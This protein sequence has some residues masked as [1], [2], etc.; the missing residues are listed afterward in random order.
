MTTDASTADE[1]S[2]TRRGFLSTLGSTAACVAAAAGRA[3]AA[4][5]STDDSPDYRVPARRKRRA[6]DHEVDVITSDEIPPGAVRETVHRR[7]RYVNV[8]P[9]SSLSRQ[10]Y[11]DFLSVLRDVLYDRTLSLVDGGFTVTG[12]VTSEASWVLCGTLP[13]GTRLCLPA[14]G[15]HRWA[16]N[17]KCV[18]A[19]V[20]WLNSDA[21]NALVK[22]LARNASPVPAFASG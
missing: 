10:Q 13:D 9:G 2:R 8:V 6:F 22:A 1:S 15:S 7:A 3:G 20:E 17:G 5:N 11:V 12:P 18:R 4:S 21:T 19:T 14:R 16:R